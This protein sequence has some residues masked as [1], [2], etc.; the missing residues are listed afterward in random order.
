MEQK[1]DDNFFLLLD[2]DPTNAWTQ[3]DLE[4]R[5]Q[6]KRREWSKDANSPSKK[7]KD[8]QRNLARMSELTAIAADPARRAEH[9][10]AAQ[11][12]AKSATREKQEQ[13]EEDLRLLQLNGYVTEAQV[14]NLAKKYAGHF[15]EKDIRARITVPI[16]KRAGPHK[17]AQEP[18]ASTLAK[19]IDVDL[20]QLGRANLYDF[21]G[22][23]E[24]TD[25]SKLYQRASEKY[26][27][28][29]IKTTKSNEDEASSRLAGHS[30]SIF[31]SPDKIAQYNETLRRKKYDNLRSS[32]D[33]IANF[34]E[35][36]E[37]SAPQ[38]KQLLRDA[39]EQGLDPDEAIAFLKDHARA[40]LY[41]LI[42]TE[43]TVQ[44]V[45][46]LQA[47]GYCRT[48]NEADDKHCT[49]CGQAL[50]E[51]CPRCGRESA[52]SNSA[53]SDCGFRLGNRTW[54]NFLLSEAIQA[55]QDRDFSLALERIEE[56]H[57]AWPAGGKD[58]LSKEL[59]RLEEQITPQ[60]EAQQQLAGELRTLLKE[61][62]FYTAQD[63]LL[64]EQNKQLLSTS[65]AEAYEQQF[66]EAIA[67]AEQR[68]SQADK[69][70]AAGNLDQ[71]V[72]YSQE[73]LGIC[74]D[75]AAAR[76]VLEKVPPAP[77]AALTAALGEKVVSL[78]WQPSASENVAY[79]IVRKKDSRPVSVNDGDKLDTVDGTLFDD[80]GAEPGLPLYYAV[81]TD[82]E[83]VPSKEGAVLQEP[84]M[85]LRDV[86]QLMAQ[87]NDRQVQLSWTPPPN[88]HEVQIIRSTTAMPRSILDGQSIPTLSN[89]QAIDNTVENDR[90]YYY[91]VFC[92]FKDVNG[93]LLTTDGAGIKAVPQVP[94]SPIDHVDI[95]A[96]G[97]PNNRVV[98]LRWTAPSKGDVVVIKAGKPT[99]LEL[100]ATLRQDDLDQYGE[101]LAAQADG[102]NDQLDQ[103]GAF[104]YVPVV[105]FGSVAYVGCE[106]RFA[107]ADD[108]SNLTVRNMGH[109]LRLQWDW[110]ENC[111]EA[112]VAYSYLDWPTLESDST[113]RARLSRAQYNLHGYFDIRDPK[114]ADHYIVVF[115]VI[116]QGEQ[117]II[118]SGTTPS[119]RKKAVLQSRLSLTY[120]IGKPF[121]KKNN[122]LS[123]Q[124][125]GKG[126]LP[127]L[128][129][130][131]KSGS[132]PM[133][134]SD[135]MLIKSIP[136]R[137]VNNDRAQIELTDAPR[138]SNLYARLFL[139]HDADLDRVSIRM[140]DQKKLRL[141]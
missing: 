119:A 74:A 56:A 82:R 12:L 59:A 83:G 36:K 129:L 137:E 126:E 132:L 106:Q 49:V 55:G 33:K 136:P 123:V 135:G 102:L 54:V 61:R 25:P 51:A 88:V 3:A 2:L 93:K 97:Q 85:I 79:S 112:I 101:L 17:P 86:D 87:V 128:V 20:A 73:A 53:C 107:S 139:Q 134:K 80:A 111:A 92:K 64:K 23:G 124:A 140:P 133:S 105:L 109:V 100:G 58:S 13:L 26:N 98:R 118:S 52:S 46:R 28:L 120:E 37:I 6:E 122:V 121:L 99:G 78:R 16:E 96:T 76:K 15:S 31:S 108:V 127:A 40:K 90:P 130:V 62:N 32:A 47:C 91:R 114:E 75:C 1:P 5:L 7:G 44:S 45:A 67:R 68:V 113:V 21:L 125:I 29:K 141:T 34:S 41:H 19:E 9:A 71:A 11:D 10:K 43:D 103:L 95:T 104:Y 22:A 4:Q 66:R 116:G 89:D 69:A 42:L 39:K 115:A 27:T 138:Q 65:Q 77:P 72:Q 35:D 30:L 84:I 48:L 24:E 8:A 18:L 81:F 117:T 63:L 14:Q 38:V 57:Q 131:G 50:R 94:P 60:K 110:P 70:I